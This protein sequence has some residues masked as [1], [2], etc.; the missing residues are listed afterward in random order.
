MQTIAV[1]FGDNYN[2]SRLRQRAQR[3]VN[4]QRLFAAID[5][6]PELSGAGVAYI[7]SAQTTIF[8]REF[9]P[10]CRREPIVVVLREPPRPMGMEAHAADLARNPR[11]SRTIAE[12]IGAAFSCSAAILSWAVVLGGIGAVPLSGGASMGLTALAYSAMIAS[13][14]Q[15]VNSGA[16][17]VSEIVSPEFNEILDSQAWYM[18]TAE[19]LDYISLA[20]ATA[21]GFAT[22][23]MVKT[24]GAQ[25]IGIREALRGLDR[26]QRARLT[27]EVIRVNHPVASNRMIKFMQKN[28][29]YPKRYSSTEISQATAL[30]IKNA[31]GATLSFTGS[32]IGG[33]ISSIAIGVYEVVEL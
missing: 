2:Q 8:L 24:L 16:R 11:E 28:G 22:I 25:G 18:I 21:S 33:N 14:L 12:G 30:H 32:A 5:A 1:G 15:C 6:D 23:K 13:S 19:V 17:T 20:G 29:R 7:D 3:A 26:T 4:L 9:S 31:L 27:K 10:I